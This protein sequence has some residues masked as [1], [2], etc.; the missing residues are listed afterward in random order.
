MQKIKLWMDKVDGLSLRERLLI[1]AACVALV[2]AI[3]NLFV[4]QP[5]EA[6]QKKL[7]AQVKQDHL[8]I[9]ATVDEISAK[10]QANRNDPDALARQRMQQ[11]QAQI[12]KIQLHLHDQQKALV[13][14]DKM[15]ALL[16]S[17]L[18]HHQSVQLRSLKTLPAV[19][20]GNTSVSA[21]PSSS[22]A[23]TGLTDENA[24]K[25]RLL[26]T[27]TPKP[28]VASTVTD[29]LAP[30]ASGLSGRAAP[31]TSTVSG[32][33]EKQANLVPQIY[34]HEVVLEL[35]GNY[36]DLLAYVQELEKKPWQLYW[37]QA[38]LK[39]EQHPQAVLSLH[40]YTLSLDQ[41]W[42]DL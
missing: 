34:R 22:A 8:Q 39:V 17:I 33:V 32:K 19:V 26:A 14:A 29:A 28:A 24:L 23:T 41:K 35:V 16:Q 7:L 6:A 25:S 1:F 38:S 13:A 31:T 30:A 15:P 18:P 9:T 20:L 27:A 21:P 12:E 3:I 37:G 2:F 5:M 4:L 36:L 10:L 42:L 11:V 40:V